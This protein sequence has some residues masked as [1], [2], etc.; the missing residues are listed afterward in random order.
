M[1]IAI[2]TDST[3]DLPPDITSKNN[4]IVIPAILIVDGKS[5]VDGDGITREAFYSRLPTMR[6]PPTTATPSLG[7]FEETF[8]NLLMS[9]Y[10]SILSIHVSSMLS[11]I[12]NMAKT[13]AQSFKDCVKVIDSGQLSL[14]IGYQV[15]A[16]TEAV[17]KGMKL[18]G[19]IQEVE[20]VR[21]RVRV[22]AMLDTLEYVRRS[23]RVTWAKAR[24]GNL[25]NI[26]PFMEVKE[27]QVLSLGQVRTR[28]K[29]I[30]SL[31]EIFLRTGSVEKLSI[32]HTNA[33]K[34]AQNLLSRLK[35]NLPEPPLI[36]N[37]TTI[38]GTHI[39]PNALGFAVVRK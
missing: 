37:V 20:K 22:V 29:G 1:T 3:A 32:L 30:N 31:I 27:G 14:G 26:K 15:L 35:S 24:I 16:A 9:G 8:E 23:G 34:D 4:I 21:Q 11:G 19:I 5:L 38:V 13:A 36:V 39:G 28:K 33:E 12:Y 2:V 25:L 10:E 7:T 17:S 18:D 6:I